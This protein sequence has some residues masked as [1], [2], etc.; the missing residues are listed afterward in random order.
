MAKRPKNP[1]ISELDQHDELQ[2]L[3]SEVPTPA[4][5]QTQHLPPIP[6]I[7]NEKLTA[8]ERMFVIA[9]CS[10]LNGKQAIEEAGYRI[11]T[12]GKQA[13]ELLKRPR[14]A[15]AIEERLMAM[16][17]CSVVSREVLITELFMLY[18]RIMEED[19]RAYKYQLAALEAIARVQG[20]YTNL[21]NV[22]HNT[23]PVEYKVVVIPPNKPTEQDGDSSN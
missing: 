20:Y 14:V 16:N 19:P 6:D 7:V 3:L 10:H 2:R 17:L 22:S 21:I 1:R 9:Y 18:N 11:Q 5:L 15:E 4:G 12:G 23:G 8:K 13:Q